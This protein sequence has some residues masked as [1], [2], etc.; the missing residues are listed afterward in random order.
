MFARY[1][2]DPE[3]LRKIVE[4]WELMP[5]EKRQKLID[6]GME[7]DPEFTALAE[8]LLMKFDDIKTLNEMALAEVLSEVPPRH[9]GYVL[10]ALPPELQEIFKKCAPLKALSE[11]RDGMESSPTP[12]DQGSGAI[13]M[14]E[15]ARRLERDGQIPV[16][17]IPR[18][19]FPK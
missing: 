10:T 19:V 17:K 18:N 13:K 15:A 14:I 3:G 11:I 9:V 7:D 5:K 12:Q 16:K 6:K 2:K 4:F 8:S 1:K